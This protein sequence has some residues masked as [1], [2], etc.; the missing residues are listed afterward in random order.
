[1][2]GVRAQART[3]VWPV[4]L[5]GRTHMEFLTRWRAV[6]AAFALTRRRG[7]GLFRLRRPDGSERE[8][9]AYYQSGWDGEPGQGWTYDTPTLTLLCPDGFWRDS[10]P[11]V[12]TRST[13]TI[14]DFLDPF[15]NI[16][17]GDVIGAT[18]MTNPGQVEA[19]PTWRLDGP[20]TQLVATNNTLGK[21]FTV[22]RT[23]TAG[24]WITISTRPGRVAT[25]GG[26]AINGAL[27]RPGS[28][29]WRLEPGVN[30]ITFTVSGSGPETKISMSFYP[31]YE[32]A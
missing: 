7:P 14:G 28:T 30:D 15:P 31:R 27:V 18:Q 29:L 22:N 10:Q 12:L 23:L 13:G 21:T 9:L 16:S 11:I 2:T 20:A 5:R 3:L 6:A 24:Q 32:T 4:R 17:S 26:T 8:C 25:S 1:M 19:W